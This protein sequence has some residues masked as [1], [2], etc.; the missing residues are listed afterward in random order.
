M[1]DLRDVSGEVQVTEAWGDVVP[2]VPRQFRATDAGSVLVREPM[3]NGQPARVCEALEAMEARS[4][5][6]GALFEAHHHTAALRYV[7]LFEDVGRG[8]VKCSD[9]ERA[10]GAGGGGGVTDE[11]VHKVGELRRLQAL[12][13]RCRGMRAEGAL[14]MAGRQSIRGPVLARKLLVDRVTMADVLLR[15]GWNAG[16]AKNRAR[17][18]QAL[19]E[20]LDA[21][22]G[23]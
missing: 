8:R 14:A 2:F 4:R 16:K 13:A 22:Y 12:L 5:R 21:I 3:P 11:I 17:L 20:C 19:R 10:G 7:T 9:L 23:W 6:A 15:H 18:V 1:Q